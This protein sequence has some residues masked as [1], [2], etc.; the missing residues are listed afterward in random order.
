MPAMRPLLVA[1][2][3][4]T[5]M[6]A[7]MVGHAMAGGPA[8]SGAGPDEARRTALYRE[9][10]DL[11]NAGKWGDAVKRFREVVA[12]RSA[13]PAL[14]TLAQAEEHTGELA[15]AERTYERA[16]TEAQAAHTADVAEAARDALS[17]I[18]PR[19][20]RLVIMLAK[21]VDGATATLDG[22]PVAIGEPVKVNPGERHVVVSAPGRRAFQSSIS[23]TAGQSVGVTAQLES[24]GTK[25]VTPT[26]TATASATPTATADHAAETR[27]PFPY[28]PVLVG[29]AGVLTGAIGAVVR[30]DGQSRYDNANGKCPNW[31]CPQQSVVDEGN[32]GRTEI[33]AGTVVIGVG[34]AA[35]VG[36]VVWWRVARP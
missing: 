17:S 1:A 33:I 11:A 31:S 27:A 19:V 2:L 26:A 16:L 6:A 32:A 10:V 23:L 3:L 29:A 4:A 34:V 18:E 12:I 24:D 5:A 14:F 15:T 9:G 35:V 13:P 20:P 22:A 28:G 25:V 7:A 8:G 36:A 21:P 30:V